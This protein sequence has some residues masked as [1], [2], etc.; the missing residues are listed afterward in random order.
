MSGDRAAALRERPL[1]RTIIGNA[2][3]TAFLVLAAMTGAAAAVPG[4]AE[5]QTS[6]V[7]YDDLD[8]STEA[9]IA[10]LER[11]IGRAADRVCGPVDRRS[12]A[13]S[14]RL[15]A[16]RDAAVAGAMKRAS[17]VIAAA[18]AGTRYALSC[19]AGPVACSR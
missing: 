16:C 10:A 6:I 9:G 15:S 8:L 7:R 12:I 19:S 14:D 4:E 17:E 1:F 18:R 11:R 2:T 13:D 3:A 5:R